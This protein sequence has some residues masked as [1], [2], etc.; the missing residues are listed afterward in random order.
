[1]DLLFDDFYIDEINKLYENY[2]DKF[3]V[4]EVSDNLCDVKFCEEE[5]NISLEECSIKSNISTSFEEFLYDDQLI[6]NKLPS[7]H[8]YLHDLI[9]EKVDFN[10]KGLSNYNVDRS[11][12]N[13]ILK[14][15]IPSKYI[16]I[17][18]GYFLNLN[19]DEISELFNVYG[20]AFGNSLDDRV[21]YC[22]FKNNLKYDEFLQLVDM[23][24]SEQLIKFFN[25]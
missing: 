20:Y 6:N 7:P 3:W 1:M 5:F 18:L 11:Y 2:L 10:F 12:L 15:K 21:I 9:I 17:N 14:G 4:D 19:L 25:K 8:E 22:A 23:H 13:R 24:G 16:L